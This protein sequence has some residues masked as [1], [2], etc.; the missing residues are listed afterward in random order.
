MTPID[1]TKFEQIK[2]SGDLPSPKGV[3]LVIMQLSQRDDVSMAELARVIKTDPA[4]VGRLLKAAN[5]VNLLGFGRRPV[6]SVQDALVVL[7]VPV[8]R[9]LALSFSLLSEYSKGACKNFDYRSYWSHSLACGL[10]MQVI[11]ARTRSAAAE[12]T[13]SVGLL[14]QIGELALATLYP[15]AYSDIL[16]QRQGVSSSDLAAAE[17]ASFAMDH[18]ELS[19]AML[20]D[21]GIPKVY[22]DAVFAHET[23]DEGSCPEGSRQYL[24]AQSLALARHV[25][26]ICLA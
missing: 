7:G 20:A 18:C 22:T 12:E 15:A 23:P 9:T 5:G 11:T 25:A 19:A 4:F 17:R 16:A 3:A 24:L 2:A 21:W 6:V 26:D 8:V 10:A 13:F 14:A 1:I